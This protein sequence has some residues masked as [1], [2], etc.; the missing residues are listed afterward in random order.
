MASIGG[1]AKIWLIKTIGV[2]NFLPEHLDNIIEATG[3]TPATNQ[4]ERHPYFNNKELI[5]EN[6]KRGIISEAWS[7]FGRE[8]NDT[9]TNNTI[10][11]IAEKYDRSP[12]QIILNWN[13][14]DHVF[15]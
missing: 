13:N 14:Q 5:A 11:E 9:L 8:I 3:V 15:Q 1:C 7:P 4:I 10:K 6:D 2:S 12:A